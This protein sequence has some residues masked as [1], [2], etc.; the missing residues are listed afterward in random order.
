MVVAVYPEHLK[1]IS[2]GAA[3]VVDDEVVVVR[4]LRRNERNDS[5]IGLL[6]MSES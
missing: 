1:S 3:F 6:Y 2:R 4:M 5:M